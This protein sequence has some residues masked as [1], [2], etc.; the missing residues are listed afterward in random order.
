MLGTVSS[1]HASTLIPSDLINE[2][3]TMPVIRSII[4]LLILLVLLQLFFPELGAKIVSIFHS[5]LTL[6]DERL[7]NAL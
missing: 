6:F 7:I 2:R 5:L 1:S 3:A 4:Q